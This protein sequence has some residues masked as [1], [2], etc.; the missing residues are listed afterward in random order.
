MFGKLNRRDASLIIV[1]LLIAAV[2]G[3]ASWFGTKEFRDQL[4]EEQAEAEAIRWGELVSGRLSDPDATFAYGKM[5]EEDQLLISTISEA[6]NVFRYKFFN[7]DGVVVL[8]SRIEDLGTRETSAA[9]TNVV[10]Q[11]R[12]YVDIEEGEE[13]PDLRPSPLEGSGRESFQN[14]RGETKTTVAEAYIPLMDAGRF[15]G[16]IE[17]Y[18]DATE[19]AA[20]LDE[21]QLEIQYLVLGML[22]LVSIVIGLVLSLNIRDRNRQVATLQKAH[23]SMSQAEEEVLRLNEELEQRV[24]TRTAELEKANLLATEAADGM[25]KLNEE[26][27]RRVE[28]RTEQMTKANDQLYRLNESM[29]KLNESLEQRVTERTV[30]LER[31]NPIRPAAQRG[32]GAAGRGAHARAAASAVR[33]GAQ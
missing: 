31:A 29:T 9:F 33:T 30:E 23:S 7:Q 32:S 8:G 28:E 17:V 18:V 5:S 2:V 11:G 12:I 10:Q 19:M 3:F 25:K 4:L 21:E 27:E 16:A 1:L 24:Q 20:F 26:L 14:L 6:G 13:F 22:A 15:K